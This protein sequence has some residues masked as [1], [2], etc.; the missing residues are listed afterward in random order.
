MPCEDKLDPVIV[1]KAAG[2]R[3]V[4][5][6]RPGY[7][8][9]TNGEGFNWF[10]V[11]GQQIRDEQRLLRL[12]RLAIPPAWTN[13]W[14]GPD[15]NGDIQAVGRDARDA[16]ADGRIFRHGQRIT[17]YGRAWLAVKCGRGGAE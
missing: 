9:K 14:I 15:A 5:D 6:D 3:Y 17:Q 13:V 7:T 12:K 10:D 2:L 4:S 8:R 16:I 11:D 1:A